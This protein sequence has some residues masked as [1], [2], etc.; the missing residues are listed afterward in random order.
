MSESFADLF[1]ESLSLT[2]MQPGK[3]VSGMVVSVGSDVVMVNAGLKSEGAIPVEEFFNEKGEIITG[4]KVSGITPKTD[5][6]LVTT[7]NTE[8][9][10]RFIIN[11]AG[12]FSDKVSELEIL[13]AKHNAEQAET[14][15]PSVV[16]SPQL[17]DKHGG[18]EYE[19]GDEYIY[20]PN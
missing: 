14:L 4:T 18:Q 9:H 8:F 13:L 12:L 15:W 5:S 11:C 19:E 20:W 3:I 7:E 2:P 6:I 10:T 17:I 16:D 1:E